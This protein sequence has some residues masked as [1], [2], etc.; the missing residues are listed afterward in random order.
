MT[1]T[2]NRE[3][4]LA[5]L[6]GV[7]RNLVADMASAGMSPA[8]L[9]AEMNESLAETC[10]WTLDEDVAAEWLNSKDFLEDVWSA[11]DP[12]GFSAQRVMSTDEDGNAYNASEAQILGIGTDG[13]AL[14][15]DEDESY[16]YMTKAEVEA[17]HANSAGFD[18]VK[19]S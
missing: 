14:Y 6:E 5:Q 16:S 17:L 3:V 7:R 12:T 13:A 11:A 9:I 4:T 10:G 15:A 18:P 19:P 8:S 1:E 2:A